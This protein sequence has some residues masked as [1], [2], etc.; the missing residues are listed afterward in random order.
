MAW[1]ILGYKN[2]WICIQAMGVCVLSF[3]HFVTIS[4][5]S[6]FCSNSDVK[7]RSRVNVERKEERHTQALGESAELRR[8]SGTG[9][10]KVALD[11]NTAKCRNMLG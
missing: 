5:P 10:G 1:N 11:R 7:P 6:R 2:G 9:S 8:N 4:L 3:S